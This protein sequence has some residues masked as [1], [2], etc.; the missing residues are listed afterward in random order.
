MNSNSNAIETISKDSKLWRRKQQY[1][2][3]PAVRALHEELQFARARHRRGG[4]T[5]YCLLPSGVGVNRVLVAGLMTG[6]TKKRSSKK[7]D[8][9]MWDVNLLFGGIRSTVSAKRVGDDGRDLIN[10]IR[11]SPA[12]QSEHQVEPVREGQSVEPVIGTAKVEPYGPDVD[13]EGDDTNKTHVETRVDI[14]LENL[15]YPFTTA[16][17]Q[18]KLRRT[19]LS[20]EQ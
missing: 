3:E 14:R 17:R 11:H 20:I 4:D 8:Y 13:D 10:W 16:A 1:F 9:E 7:D 6:V 15:E 2:R 12:I 5:S 19:A 18:R